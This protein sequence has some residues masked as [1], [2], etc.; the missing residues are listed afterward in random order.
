MSENTIIINKRYFNN[1]EKGV[2]SLNQFFSSNFQ[3]KNL[4]KVNDVSDLDQGMKD[5]L[6]SIDTVDSRWITDPELIS[7]AADKINDSKDDVLNYIQDK[8]GNDIDLL[9]YLEDKGDTSLLNTTK[10][11]LSFKALEQISD[12]MPSF[13]KLLNGI[14]SFELFT[15]P[16]KYK[17]EVE[18]FTQNVPKGECSDT[19]GDVKYS[20]F[21][22]KEYING[23][24]NNDDI[25]MPENMDVQKE[26]E[27]VM[28]FNDMTPNTKVVVNDTVQEAA[29]T[30]YFVDTKPKNIR[31]SNGKWQIS[32]QFEKSV[33]DMISG[34]RKYD[35]SDDLKT[36]IVSNASKYGKT[37]SDTVIPFILVG[38]FIKKG[39]VDSCK[40]YSDSYRSIVNKNNGAKR[41]ENYD[42]FTTFKSD[43]EGT[44]Q[45][46]S[47]FCKLK[48]VND[49]N[50]KI[51]NNTLLTLF[52]IFDSRIYFDIMYNMIPDKEKKDKGMD[53]DSFVR[54]HRA[55]INNNSRKSNPYQKE[56]NVD[57]TESTTSEI[58]E[59]S[60]NMIRSMG[61]MNTSDMTL[62]ESWHD[63]LHDEIMTVDDGLY[64][65]HIPVSATCDYI[66]ESFDVINSIAT[67]MILEAF[68][69]NKENVDKTVLGG[70]LG[71]LIKDASVIADN[72]TVTLTQLLYAEKIDADGAQMISPI[73]SKKSRGK[74]IKSEIVRDTNS[75]ITALSKDTDEIDKYIINDLKKR[76]RS[77]SETLSF[78]IKRKDLF[79]DDERENLVDLHHAAIKIKGALSPGD[80]K[81]NISI[82]NNFFNA[83]EIVLK[84]ITKINPEEFQQQPVDDEENVSDETMVDDTLETTEGESVDNDTDKSE[85]K[86][87]DND[88]DDSEDDDDDNDEKNDD[89]DDDDDDKEDNTKD[90]QES[91]FQEV[92]DGS[93]PEYMKTRMKMTD[94]SGNKPE[95][96][97]VPASLPSEDP[98]IPSN[99]ISDL[100]MSIDAKINAA[101]D[102][103]N[104]MLGRDAK[105]EGKNIVY[106]ITNNYTYTNSFNKTSHNDL[107]QNKHIDQSVH[108]EDISSK[109]KSNN[110]YNSADSSD[111]KEDKKVQEFSTGYSVD[112]VFAFLKSEEPLLEASRAIKPPKEDSLTRAM[113]RAMDRDRKSLPKQQAAKQTVDKAVGTA[114][115]VT[116]PVTRTKHWLLGIV[117][118]LVKRNEDK[119][120]AEIIESPSYRTALFKAGRLAIKIGL[121]GVA[122][123]IN[124]YL[125][126]AYLL[127]QASNVY[128]KQRL[129][130]EVEHEFGVEMRILDD[131]IRLADEENTPESRKA[132]W[133]MMR[134][135]GKMETIATKQAPNAKIKHPSVAQ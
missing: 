11:F 114:K 47:D 56:N 121:T 118:S 66:G 105:N 16:S 91:T 111:T 12:N 22:L 33:D 104:E 31:Y 6:D 119:V 2:N 122:F 99:S 128:D 14:Y 131:K 30:N 134:L 35:S 113:T 87:D 125:G 44:L 61:D 59:Y 71:N 108:G 42:I 133:Q 8:E 94:D 135:R 39:N 26:T 45:F 74:S 24:F 89:N 53:E 19:L 92:D 50:A 81:R 78:A 95:A 37:L 48:L 55:I 51:S 5:I 116:K 103:V 64:N 60:Y 129:R 76:A 38:A 15:T 4:L 82:I 17:K 124:G 20:V 52:N 86:D 72:D 63:M 115:A 10:E 49:S 34:L 127:A 70:L 46:I 90:V 73:I 57:D 43:K 9:S 62:C 27:R 77:L 106:N 3:Q 69:E 109:S 29:E 58:N 107:S 132:K 32:T 120:K 117:D 112:D 41:F 85:S 65:A 102:N 28:S 130:K 54:K 84:M 88:D 126:A 18:L 96:K 93:I 80:Y 79:K 1:I 123:T 98:D 13:E 67:T 83:A 101:G 100:A 36:F 40:K 25:E 75:I 68:E 97:V 7:D 23:I 21:N 110:K